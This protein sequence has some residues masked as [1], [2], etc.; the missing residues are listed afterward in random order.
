MLIEPRHIGP[1]TRALPGWCRALTPDTDGI[2]TRGITRQD[3]FETDVVG[4]A[5]EVVVDV[6]EALAAPPADIP[7]RHVA[8]V[9]TVT[10][11]VLAVDVEVVQMLATPCEGDL[12]DVVEMRER[13]V[14]R[15]EEVAPDERADASQNNTQLIDSGPWRSGRRYHALSIAQRVAPLKDSPPDFSTLEEVHGH[16]MADRGR[17]SPRGPRKRNLRQNPLIVQI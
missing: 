9:H 1:R 6:P 17:S 5:S 8:G 3:R 4:P 16:T 14:A 10:T 7:Q 15:D 11:V 2:D 12:Q 13:R